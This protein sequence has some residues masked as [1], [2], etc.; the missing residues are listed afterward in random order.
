M[1]IFKITSFV[2]VLVLG[3]L[4][5]RADDN[6]DQAAARAALVSKLFE[7]G[8]ATPTNNA[9]STPMTKAPASV[10]IPTSV[11]AFSTTTVVKPVVK[12][13]V[14]VE[15]TTMHPI[16]QTKPVDLDYVPMSSRMDAGRSF[17]VLQTPHQEIQNPPMQWTKSATAP[18]VK[19]SPAAATVVK[20]STV[21]ST[22]ATAP[23]IKM[24]APTTDK[25]IIG[26]T[27]FAPI[28]APVLPIAGDKQ[29]KLLDLLAKYKADQISPEEYHRQRAAIISGM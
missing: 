5:L 21:S 15:N 7:I 16:N 10:S 6:A 26:N 17:H 29:Q 8:G 22:S 13:V 2:C 14:K 25:P 19:M 1:Q 9:N 28:V 4:A 23:K 3:T 27:E 24:S 12:P 11:P 20:K 18:A